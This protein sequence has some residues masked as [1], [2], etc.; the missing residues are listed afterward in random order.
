MKIPVT[1]I[2]SFALL[3]ALFAGFQGG[4]YF[5]KNR[6]QEIGIA[7]AM[8]L[9]IYAGVQ[10]A[11]ISQKMRWNWW[12]FTPILLILFIIGCYSLIFAFNAKTPIFPSMMASREFLLI[13]IAPS[14]YMLY[15]SG[16]TLQQIERIFI[17][18]LVILLFNYLFHYFHMDLKAAFFSD[19]PTIHHLVS[20]DEWRGFRL[21]APTYPIIILMLYSIMRFFQPASIKIKLGCLLCLL[22]CGY[23]GSLV[24]AR[25]VAATLILAIFLYPFCF[26]RPNRI[27]LMVL[28]LP[29][30]IFAFYFT[31]DFIIHH[32]QSAGGGEIRLDSYKIAWDNFLRHPFL[33][34]GQSSGYSKTYQDIFGPK[35]FPSDLGIIGMAFKY[36]IVGIGLYIYFDFFLLLRLTKVNW[37]YRKLKG[38]H[39]PLVLALVIFFISLTINIFLQPGLAYAQGI[40]VGSFSMGYTACCFEEISAH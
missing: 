35:F 9:F 34:F 19:D 14:V 23:V 24:L 7:S 15:R 29:I 20:Y 3:I 6:F 22:L 1:L 21:K 27:N 4:R 11:F 26:S 13:F 2:I 38:M 30:G 28:V 31:F 33:G 36:G 39:H 12:F 10:T 18:T 40:T 37:F 25:A 16:L 32:F 17:A 8:F 5:M